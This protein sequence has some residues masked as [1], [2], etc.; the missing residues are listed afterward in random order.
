MNRDEF[1]RVW[2]WLEQA[3]AAYGDTHRKAHVIEAIE[4]EQAVL[5]SRPGAAMVIEINTWPTGMKEAVAWLAGGDL[6]TIRAMT[7]EIEAWAKARGCH[8]A[9]VNAGRIGWAKALGDY[10]ARGV[11]LTKDL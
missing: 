1:E 2:P 11:Y 6:K 10:R 7:P 4:T 9:A 8:R 5:F 3:L